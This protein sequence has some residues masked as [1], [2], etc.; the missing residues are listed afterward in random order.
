MDRISRRSK[1]WPAVSGL[2]AS[3]SPLC[4]VPIFW[5]YQEVT[6]RLNWRVCSQAWSSWEEKSE[7]TKWCV[8]EEFK[9]LWVGFTSG[10]REE[11]ESA[12]IWTLYPSL[13][14]RELS[15]KSKLSIYCSVY[16]PA[17]AYGRGCKQW[18]QTNICGCLFLLY[19][20]TLQWPSM[21][22]HCQ[23]GP[24]AH[25]SVNPVPSSSSCSSS[26]ERDSE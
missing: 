12:G 8:W 14:W 1:V 23:Q 17:L 19:T 20:R 7:A 15:V 9:Y 5:L 6:S 13:R 24:T 3:G 21:R 18:Y 25:L 26:P 10:W 2:V 22:R 11:Q 4:F 16:V